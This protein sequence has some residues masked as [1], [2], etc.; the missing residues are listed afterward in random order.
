DSPREI[1]K[2]RD[3]DQTTPCLTNKVFALDSFLAFLSFFFAIWNPPGSSC[4]RLGRC[5]KEHAVGPTLGCILAPAPR[6]AK[7]LPACRSCAGREGLVEGKN[8][9]RRG[10]QLPREAGSRWRRGLESGSS[11]SAPPLLAARSVQQFCQTK[12]RAEFLGSKG[13]R[14]LRPSPRSG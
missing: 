1:D 7:H 11:R 12:K 13:S 9:H 10:D 3:P 5:L 6:Q 8:S 2:E 14:R 4:A